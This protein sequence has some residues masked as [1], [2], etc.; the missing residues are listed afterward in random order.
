MEFF[1]PRCR[2]SPAAPLVPP[3]TACRERKRQE[4]DI[5]W[6]WACWRAFL[7]EMK[8]G[9]VAYFQAFDRRHIQVCYD[10][11][12][13]FRSDDIASAAIYQHISQGLTAFDPDINKA[14]GAVKSR[15]AC[16][17]HPAF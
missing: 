2:F 12:L 14:F 16:Q 5:N 7:K 1:V 3:F 11:L 6:M 10:L 15:M 9:L 17:H 4:V 13:H 8:G